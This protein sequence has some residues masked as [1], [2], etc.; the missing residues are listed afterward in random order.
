[1]TLNHQNSNPK[2]FTTHLSTFSSHLKPTGD[3]NR[4]EANSNINNNNNNH[5]DDHNLNRQTSAM[6]P[7]DE[8]EEWAKISEIME[9]FGS[10]IA[11]ES[12]FVH[13]IENEFQKR[14][15]LK[16]KMDEVMKISSPIEEVCENLTPLKRWLTDINLENLEEYLM[17]NGFDNPDYINGLINNE[18]DLEIIGIPVKERSVLLKEITKLPKPHTLIEA[19]S[20]SKLNNNQL[21]TPTVDEWLASIQ[22]EEYIEV[23]K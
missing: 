15:G 3:I 20:N 16:N 23:F 14:L 8:Q 1:M 11:R 19:N 2:T 21:P 5:S 9:S 17:E 12:V 22:L 6:S 10:G 7:F 4:N 13:D 18:N